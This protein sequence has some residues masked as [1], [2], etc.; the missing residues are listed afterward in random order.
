MAYPLSNLLKVFTGSHPFSELA[1]AAVVFKMV[2]NCELP[3]RPQ[4]QGLTDPVRDM[5]VQCW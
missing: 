2:I 3:D 5:T 1:P 4:G